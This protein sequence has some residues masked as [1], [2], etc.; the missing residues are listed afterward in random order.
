VNIAVTS[1]RNGFTTAIKPGIIKNYANGQKQEVLVFL[2]FGTKIICFLFY[3]VALPLFLEIY[4]VLILWLGNPPQYTGIFIRLIL[5]DMLVNSFGSSI[6]ETIIM[7]SGRIKLY[8][9]LT[10]SILLLSLPLAWV[11]M[12]NGMQ[13]Y[14]VTIIAIGL[15]AVS[16]LVTILVTKTIFDFFIVEFFLN[17]LLPSFFS[18]ALSAVAPLIL[19]IIFKESVLR[20][21]MVSAISV[22]SVCCAMYGIA[23]NRPEKEMIKDMAK[24]KAAR[25]FSKHASRS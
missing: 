25:M 13:P 10:N 9:M 1:F 20:L 18:F 24:R 23:L 7:A 2:F 5:I 4:F 15:S 12:R 21:L 22:V 19:H 11:A 16:L 17:V 6:L 3:V 8:I 14:I